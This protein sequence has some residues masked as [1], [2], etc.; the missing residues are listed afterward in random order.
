MPATI[1]PDPLPAWVR[2][3]PLRKSEIAVY[4]AFRRQLPSRYRVYYSSPWLGTESDGTE[5]DGE[6]DFVVA[7]AET[8]FL[9]IEVKGGGVGRDKRTSD[10]HSVDRW[11]SK[12]AI[13]N[14]VAQATKSKHQLLQRMRTLPAMGNRW[15]S[16]GIAVILPDS[17]GGEVLDG[18]DTPREKF[19]LREDMERLG[20]WVRAHLDHNMGD[21]GEPLGLEGIAALDR[22][23]AHAFQLHLPLA[24]TLETDSRKVLTATKEQCELLQVL[25]EHRRVAIAGVAGSGKTVIAVHK[26]MQLAEADPEARVLLTCFNVP[27]GEH[28]KRLTARQPNIVAGPFHQ[29][30]ARIAREAGLPTPPT[31]SV[32]ERMAEAWPEALVTAVG[33][34]PELAFDAIIVDEGQDFSDNWLESL[35]QCASDD[36][37]FWVLYDDNQRLYGR[38]SNFLSA[39]PGPPFKLRRNVRNPKPVFDRLVPLFGAIAATSAGPEG[40]PVEEIVVQEE[41][42]MPSALKNL[43]TRLVETEQVEP[44]EI[45]VLATTKARLTDLCPSSRLGRVAV[46]DATE[47]PRGRVCMDTVRRFKGLE[48]SVII[49]VDPTEMAASDEL[50]YVGLSR[51]TGHLILLGTRIPRFDS[52]D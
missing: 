9:V 28:L 16:A 2:D 7:S 27:L 36:A 35:N 34:L 25:E 14:P 12:H 51:P 37:C 23:I 3:N 4:D 38:S 21:H 20:D 11:G 13:K 41:R 33:S 49:L 46:C 43:V 31:E 30:C 26:A 6:A 40:R 8:G 15:I 22:M 45:A 18:L 1:H 19:A 48:R 10:W 24:T 17:S 39:F 29:V 42:L 44:E 32:E 5:K 50:Q 47:Q 52:E